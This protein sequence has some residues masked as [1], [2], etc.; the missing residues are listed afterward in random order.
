MTY[1]DRTV[2][3][4]V[5]ADLAVMGAV[6][7]EGVRGCGKTETGFQHANSQFRVDQA[8]NRR[9]A[10]LNPAAALEGAMPRLIDEWQLA[11]DLWNEVRHEID[12]RREPGQFILSGSATPADDATRHTGAGRISRIRMRPMALG[13][14]YPQEQRVTLS[15]LRSMDY[16]PALTGHLSYRDLAVE[17]VRGGWPFLISTKQPG[18]VR[19]V[20]NY[21]EN[22]VHA[23]ISQLGTEYSPMRVRRLLSSVARNISSEAAATTLAADVSA[24]GGKL[25]AASAR[26][27]LDALT[28]I[29]VL[30]E[31]PAWSGSLRSKTRLRQQPK[32]H[33]CDPSLACAALRITPEALANDPEYF[34]QIFESMAVR[35]LRVYADQIDA[36]CFGYRDGAGLE[37][38]VLIE[39]AEGGWAGVEVKL[40][41]SDA[42]IRSAEKNLLRLANYRMTT[43]PEFL[44]VVTGGSSVFTLPSGVHVLPLSVLGPIR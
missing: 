27:Y 28:R 16:L 14:T 5:S 25:S 13:E 11:P 39:F 35:D 24:D 43:N 41:E 8:Q 31:L 2:D 32:L 21:L 30:E 38:D 22:I 6:L 26:E 17:A 12:A 44:V 15:Q 33:F 7:L 34:G 19:Y 37:V 20:R 36:S 4:S 23:D 1:I 9:L 40:G 18:F 3:Y 10:V 42:V 29:F